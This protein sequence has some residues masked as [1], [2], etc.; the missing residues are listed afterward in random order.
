MQKV[1]DIQQD[2]QPLIAYTRIPSYTTT[3]DGNFLEVNQAFLDVLEFTWEELQ[4]LKAIE[5]FKNKPDRQDLIQQL[6]QTGYYN[7]EM[8]I[9]ETKSGK[10]LYFLESSVKIKDPLYDFILQGFLL[11]ITDQIEAEDRL[12]ILDRGI[13]KAPMSVAIWNL[14]DEIEYVNPTFTKLTGYTFEQVKG[15]SLRILGDELHS[16]EDFD[17]IKMYIQNNKIWKGV[18]RNHRPNGT[19]Y[20][21]RATIVPVTNRNNEIT[22]FLS[23]YQDITEELQKDMLI[24]ESETKFRMLFDHAQ[25]G[26]V[27]ANPIDNIVDVNDYFANMIGYQREELIG[28]DY[29]LFTHPDDIKLTQQFLDEARLKKSTKSYDKRYIT[30][31]GDIVW[32]SISVSMAT[33]S[34]ID[35]Y[36]LSISDITQRKLIEQR[37]TELRNNL[38]QATKFEAIGR[39]SGNIAHDFN[40]LLTIIMNNTELIKI[41]NEDHQLQPY[42]DDIERSAKYGANIVANLLRYSRKSPI[43][44][45]ELSINQIL[46]SIITMLET[47][48]GPKVKISTAFCEDVTVFGSESDLSSAI[49][50]LSLNAIEALPEG[51]G[52]V[53]ITSKITEGYVSI[54]IDDTG[55]GMSQE[56]IDQIF[57]PFYSTKEDG[58]G[59]GLS[60]ALGIIKEHGGQLSVNSVVDK[61]T[62][63]VVTF[64]IFSGGE[65][66]NPS[67][68]YLPPIDLTENLHLMFVDDE[69]SILTSFFRYFA[70]RG[71]HVSTY[72]S[73]SQAEHYYKDHWQDID[74]VIL[75]LNLGD[76]TGLETLHMLESINPRIKTIF[77]SGYLDIDP[78]LEDTTSV[79]KVLTKPMNLK[80][81]EREIISL[82]TSSHNP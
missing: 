43:T 8:L 11:D 55:I 22:H 34:E 79:L 46:R 44:K 33:L 32:G 49:M 9:L 73:A 70:E 63:F 13:E 39:L 18:F 3:K 42:L 14:R 66:N 69:R 77:Y 38:L 67:D 65:T 17:E 19:K 1:R 41:V 59:L 21:I 20:T 12:R 72:D 40:N 37:E 24:K 61:G 82:L 30:K 16:R 45:T 71:Y 2:Y 23:V 5:L 48:R 35:H 54:R 29:D 64:P 75:D 58:T 80:S 7:D 26:I 76:K 6:S 52:Q 74:L 51:G 27:L 36:V 28:K 78:N 62:S 10:T 31:S 60:S 53:S 56:M 25:V 57:E 50:N 15:K 81:L 68:D 4:Q 47:G